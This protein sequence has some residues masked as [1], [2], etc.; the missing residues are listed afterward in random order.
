MESPSRVT[1][2][3]Q[4]FRQTGPAGPMALIVT[5]LPAVGAIFLF[6]FAPR[7]APW[8]RDQGW[9]GLLIF[10]VSFAVLGGFALVPTY[11]NSI[12]GGWTF[13]FGWGFPAVMAGLGGAAVI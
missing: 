10:I 9:L 3:R 8:L 11:A 7:L 1:R 2:A 12:V 6:W 13:K 4:F 5:A